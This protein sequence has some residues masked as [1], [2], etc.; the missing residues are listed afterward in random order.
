MEATLDK[1]VAHFDALLNTVNTIYDKRMVK[2]LRKR[3]ETLRQLA[4][5]I[6]APKV[7][8]KRKSKIVTKAQEELKL[9]QDKQRT[10]KRIAELQKIIDEGS[11]DAI[12]LKRQ[13]QAS[14]YDQEMLDLMGR[15]RRLKNEINKK[16]AM[17]E[18]Q[19]ENRLKRLLRDSMVLP[20]TLKAMA[21]MSA[22]F[23]QA[24]MYLGKDPVGWMK[25]FTRGFGVFFNAKYADK[26]DGLT[27]ALARDYG[28][29]NFGIDLTSTE[30]QINQKEEVFLTEFFN[31]PII[32]QTIGKLIKDPSER[33]YVNFL[34]RMR[35]DMCVG[36]MK[37][38]PN[39]TTQEIMEW[40]EF[41]NLASGRGKIGKKFD[42][43]LPYLGTVFFAPRLTASRFKLPYYSIGKIAKNIVKGRGV[44]IEIETTWIGFESTYRIID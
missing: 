40:V 12:L 4:D 42:N 44:G 28:L 20:R 3:I 22:A 19:Q 11:Y 5:D 8:Q 6:T 31:L 34:N 32:K 13:K 2:E 30:G 29:D 14:K 43:A 38:H 37:R 15:E 24:I 26:M 17:L 9:L 7:S 23:N 33:H 16:I 1:L 27:R 10:K 41:V 35:V 25:T 21:D 18:A 39:A 36:F